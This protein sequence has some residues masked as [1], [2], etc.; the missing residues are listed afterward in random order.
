MSTDKNEL[1]DELSVEL[2][3]EPSDAPPAD[4]IPD[5]PSDGAKAPKWRE[6]LVALGAH[7]DSVKDMKADELAKLADRLG[8]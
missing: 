4:S 6:Y 3:P 5:R 8:G 7:P 1:R 2:N